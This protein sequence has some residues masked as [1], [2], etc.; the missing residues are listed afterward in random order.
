MEDGNDK[1][2][3]PIECIESW[4]QFLRLFREKYVIYGCEGYVLFLDYNYF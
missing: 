2:N 3:K 1:N 4:S